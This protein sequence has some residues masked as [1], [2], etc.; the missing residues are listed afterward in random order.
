M[1]LQPASL[2]LATLK[3][4]END[5]GFSILP[6]YHGSLQISD[7]KFGSPAHISGKIE[8]GDEIVQVNKLHKFCL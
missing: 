6:N 7:I 5:L 4:R 3:K 8:E 2:D 1:L